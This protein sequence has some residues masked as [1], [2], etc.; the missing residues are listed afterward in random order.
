MADLEPAASLEATC[1]ADEN[2]DGGWTELMGKDMLLKV[3]VCY[4][5]VYT[6]CNR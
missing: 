2:D 6:L 1:M 4:C 5:T 3:C